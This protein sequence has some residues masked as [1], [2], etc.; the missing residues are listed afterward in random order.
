MHFIDIAN[1]EQFIHA[2]P[3]F[4]FYLLF[5]CHRLICGYNWQI[6]TVWRLW[7]YRRRTRCF[8]RFLG[9]WYSRK[10][11]DGQSR[12]F[13]YEQV[14]SWYRMREWF[15]KILFVLW[16]SFNDFAFK[17]SDDT[18]FFCLINCNMVMIIGRSGWLLW[19]KSS[20]SHASSTSYWLQKKCNCY[21]RLFQYSAR[22]EKSTLWFFQ[23]VCLDRY[24]KCTVIMLM[25]ILLW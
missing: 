17:R 10:K 19:S 8:E 7:I 16:I 23:I 9:L 22:Y 2:I 4:L 11:W 15:G 5:N 3:I 18:I 25:L 1:Y 13:E 12:R 20:T 14:Y 24:Y 21:R 6:C